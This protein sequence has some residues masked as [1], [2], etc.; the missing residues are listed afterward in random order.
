MRLIRW[1]RSI[2]LATVIYNGIRTGAQPSAFDEIAISN[3]SLNELL[4]SGP[5]A[6][7]QLL[8]GLCKDLAFLMKAIN[9]YL[10]S[11]INVIF[12][13]T[14]FMIYYTLYTPPNIEVKCF[15]Q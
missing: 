10:K 5:R 6:S 9:H 1:L 14:N 13:R 11:S 12:V 7:Q 2:A 3:I 15:V 8:N 4:A